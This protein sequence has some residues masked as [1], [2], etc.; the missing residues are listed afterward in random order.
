MCLVLLFA[1]ITVAT[2]DDTLPPREP[3]PAYPAPSGDKVTPGAIGVRWS[4]SGAVVTF[5]GPG[6]LAL[7]GGWMG[8]RPLPDVCAEEPGWYDVPAPGGW[9]PE[10][11]PGD[12][13]LLLRD[14]AVVGRA[15]LG[16]RHTVALP[17]I[18]R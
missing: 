1:P 2:A 5:A 9:V 8:P 4:D 13:Y 7:D 10:P 18:R 17:L 6:C 11:R 16:D 3:V 12:A 15:A 14:G